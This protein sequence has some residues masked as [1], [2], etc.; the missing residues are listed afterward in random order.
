MTGVPDYRAI[1]LR[2]LPKDPFMG[3]DGDCLFCDGG[4]LGC[5][6]HRR[7]CPWLEAAR[8]LDWPIAACRVRHEPDPRLVDGAA[9]T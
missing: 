9:T 3:P 6:H 5:Q 1:L 4:M 2:V 8:A 7:E